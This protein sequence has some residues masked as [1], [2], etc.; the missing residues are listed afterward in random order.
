MKLRPYQERLEADIWQAWARPGVRVVLAVLPTGGGKSAILSAVVRKFQGPAVV[1]AHRREIIGQLSLALARE[2]VRHRIIGPPNLIKLCVSAH[3]EEMGRSWFDPNARVAVASVQS[4]SAKTVD[5]AWAAQVGLWVGDEGHHYTATNEFGRAVKFFPNAR[6]LLVTATPGRADGLGLGSHADGLADA[7]VLGPCGRDLI[8]AGFLSRYKLFA[9]PSTL[10]REDIPVTASGD[11]SPTKLREETGRS[12]VIG[13]VVAHYTKHAPG[14]LS[15]TF[16]DSIENA[17]TIA[18]KFRDAGVRAEV[19]TGKSPDEVRTSILR[20]FKQRQV[21][22]LVS[23]ALVDE[24]FDCPSVECVF[25][26]AATESFGRFAQRFGRGLRIMDGKSHMMYFDHVGNLVRHGNPT[27]PREWTLNRRAKRATSEDDAIPLRVCSNAS[28]H[29]GAPPVQGLAT[30]PGEWAG[31]SRKAGEGIRSMLSV[32]DDGAPVWLYRGT[33][34]VCAERYERF[35]KACPHCGFQPEPQ[36]RSSPEFV[37]GDLTELDD[38]TLARLR[39]EVIDL[40]APPPDLHFLGPAAQGGARKNHE[41]R[42]SAQQQL[43]DLIALWAGWQRAQGRSDSY[44]YRLFYH[45]YGHTVLGA[46]ALG[47]P[48]ALALV[49]RLNLDLDANGVTEA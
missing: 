14:K 8:D 48:D 6:G 15:L 49:L 27:A 12:S 1:M 21:L 7:M 11:F 46:Q 45:T 36:S 35:H 29:D 19:L 2:G 20:Q 4:I 28:K 33:G 42:A 10:H 17:M 30:T 38:E 44:A 25:D 34:E 5:P 9:P 24:G 39:G 37:D 26:A 47:G 41:R 16:A 40:D 43:R 23:V 32:P 18:G 22:Q 13:D 3:M 31:W